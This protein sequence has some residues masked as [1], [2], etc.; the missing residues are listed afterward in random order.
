[1]Q[2]KIYKKILSLTILFTLSFSLAKSQNQG[3]YVDTIKWTNSNS[4]AVKIRANGFN[5]VIGFQGSIKW[6]RNTLQYTS[7]SGNPALGTSNYSFN[8]T[9]AVSQGVLTYI[10]TDAAANHTEI[11]GTEIITINFNVINNPLSTYNNNIVYFDNT[12]TQIGIDTAADVANLSDLATLS[13][14]NLERHIAGEVSFARPP[15]LSISNGNVTDSITNRPV[16][17]TFQW[18]VNGNPEVGTDIAT[19]NNAPDGNVCLTITYPNNNSVNCLA[20]VLPVKFLSFDGRIVDNIVKL[21]WA[22][23][24]EINNK[25]FAVEKSFD[26]ANFKQIGFINASAISSYKFNDVTFNGTK[27]F[28]RLKQIDLNGNF[29][30]S[31]TILINAKTSSKFTMYPNPTKSFVNISGEKIEQVVVR[32]MLGKIVYMNNFKDANNVQIATNNLTTGTYNVSVTTKNETTVQ[33]LV[34]Q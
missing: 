7:Q 21:E 20:T 27:S 24:K 16:G 29:S 13:S 12:P 26:G 2:K 23:A 9:S 8:S 14:P 4:I 31:K 22:T 25:G 28:Y 33:R 5:N 19:F 6:D 18:T 32:D 11:D 30:Y 1:M 17:T 34:I 3:L 15:V 10:Y